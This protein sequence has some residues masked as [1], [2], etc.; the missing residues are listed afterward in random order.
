V[1]DWLTEADVAA[2]AVMLAGCLLVWKLSTRW[3]RRFGAFASALIRTP[4]AY[5]ALFVLVL[6]GLL[7]IATLPEAA[8]VLPAVDA[9][10]LDIVTILVALELRHYLFSLA[11]LAGGR[12]SVHGLRRGLAPIVGRCLAFVVAPTKP[13]MLPYTCVWLLIA[14]RIVMGSMKVPPHAHG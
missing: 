12:T 9:V 10:G 5:R 4:P 1:R 2:F 8:M 13:E 14:C 6:V 11:R 3:K 7:L